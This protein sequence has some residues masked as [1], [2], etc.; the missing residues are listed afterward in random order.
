MPDPTNK[1]GSMQAGARR[2]SAQPAVTLLKLLL[3][4]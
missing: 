3:S 2:G 4:H 1:I